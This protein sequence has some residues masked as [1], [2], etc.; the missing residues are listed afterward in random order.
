M[1][2]LHI[3]S[4]SAKSVSDFKDTLHSKFV[5]KNET[6]IHDTWISTTEICNNSESLAS[7]YNEQIIDSFN[8]KRIL[9]FVH[10]DVIIEDLYLH[11]KLN[12]AMER[13]DIVGLA[14]IKAPIT[15][16]S[17]A[18]WHLLGHPSQYSGSVAHFDKDG[19]KRFMTTYG[20][21]PERVVLLDGLFIAINTERIL[22]KG[23]LFDENNP[24][25]FHY[26]DLNFC[27]QANKLGLKL[28]TWPIWVT[29]KSHGL[30]QPT[31]D[32][33]KGQDYFLNKWNK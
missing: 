22:E 29:H 32:W 6:D 10:D 21:S 20:P 1:K 18:L 24:A 19:I 28:G 16:K 9:V 8:K 17:P 14:G 27:L 7:V 26:Y 30:E 13:F 5:E 3:V 4:A 23:L 11:E 2:H 31:E 15:I 25:K 33:K 12:E